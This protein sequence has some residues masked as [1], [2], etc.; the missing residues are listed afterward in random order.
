MPSYN[1]SRVYSYKLTETLYTIYTCLRLCTK[2]VP[3]ATAARNK[4]N[5]P[6]MKS[7][8]RNKTR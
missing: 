2:F 6:T 4:S 3:I 1:S 8:D 7:K 5:S